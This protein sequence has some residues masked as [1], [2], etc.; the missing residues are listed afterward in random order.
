M[1]F[2]VKAYIKDVLRTTQKTIGIKKGGQNGNL[3]QTTKFIVIFNVFKNNILKCQI[4]KS[5]S[6]GDNRKKQN[7]FSL[8]IQHRKHL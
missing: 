4:L 6:D 1:Q 2:W 3:T 8:K 7:Y 5:L